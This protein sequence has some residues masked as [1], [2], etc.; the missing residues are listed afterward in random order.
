M[1]NIDDYTGIRMTIWTADDN[2][3]CKQADDTSKDENGFNFKKTVHTVL[4]SP[5]FDIATTALFIAAPIASAPMMASTSKVLPKVGKVLKYTPNV[6][7]GI[8]MVKEKMEV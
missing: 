7:N 3:D 4:E 6:I 2:A 8:V 1:N 5:L